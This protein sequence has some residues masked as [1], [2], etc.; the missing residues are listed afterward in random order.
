[1][2]YSYSFMI[3]QTKNMTYKFTRRFNT[4]LNVIH[5]IHIF[6]QSNYSKLQSTLG[7]FHAFLVTLTDLL[8]A[9]MT[10]YNIFPVGLI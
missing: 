6:R 2:L 10:V 1:M 4:L 8:T 3:N 9:E 5:F 7:N